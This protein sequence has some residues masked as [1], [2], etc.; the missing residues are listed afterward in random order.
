MWNDTSPSRDLYE[1][2]GYHS[3]ADESYRLQV[4]LKLAPPPR[5]LKYPLVP[6]FEYGGIKCEYTIGYEVEKGYGGEFDSEDLDYCNLDSPIWHRRESDGSCGTEFITGI[7]P[8]APP[9]AI[10]DGVFNE[11]QYSSD[12]FEL[13]ADRRCAGH[14]TVGINGISGSKLKKKIRPYLGIVYAVWRHRLKNDFVSCDVLLKHDGGDPRYTPVLVKSKCLEFRI[15]RRF[16]N[17][18]HAIDRYNFFYI[19][20]DGVA[21]GRSR[22]S[23]YRRLRPIIRGMYSDGSKVTE[24]YRIAREFDKFLETEELNDEVRNWLSDSEIRNIEQE[25]E[26]RIRRERERREREQREREQR[27]RERREREQRNNPSPVNETVPTDGV[28]V[29]VPQP[30]SASSSRNELIEHFFNYLNS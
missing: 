26:A 2:R 19:L 30:I 24:V 13:A 22:S 11:F 14:V 23:V 5:Q 17:V 3:L 6:D 7:M 12:I 21:N 9:G 10:R 15:V 16:E 8:L 28:Y 25:K 29:E 4:G 18:K 27:E 20:I 1:E